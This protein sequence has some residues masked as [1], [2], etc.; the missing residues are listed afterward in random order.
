MINRVFSDLPG[1]KEVSFDSGL[2]VVLA[3]RTLESTKK[4]TRN[5]LG[6]STLIA[7]IHFVLG[8][9]LSAD[10]PLR[11][12]ELHGVTFGLDLTLF[13]KRITATRSTRVPNQVLVTGDLPYSSAGSSSP[14]KVGLPEWTGTLGLA[15]FGL[16]AESERK[17]RPTFRSAISYVARSGKDAYS[18]PFRRIVLATAR[19]FSSVRQDFFH[20]RM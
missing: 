13:G 1:F 15:W 4:D 10:N 20:S 9:K 12:P 5:G 16:P 6:K 7:I 14:K 19:S 3:D 18:S 8:S 11:H 17:Y 2:N